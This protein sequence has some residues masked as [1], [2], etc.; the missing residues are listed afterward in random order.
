[1]VNNV[2]AS[3]ILKIMSGADNQCY[4]CVEE[5]FKQFVSEFGFKELAI[6]YFRDL[7]EEDLY[8]ETTG[9]H[10]SGN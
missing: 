6:K 1:M 7:Y 10:G 8:G 4:Y 9:S 5:L 3:K 2:E